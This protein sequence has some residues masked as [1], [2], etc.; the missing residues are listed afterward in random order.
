MLIAEIL[1]WFLLSMGRKAETV[2]GGVIPGFFMER[3]T[4]ETSFAQA[5][6]ASRKE[7]LMSGLTSTAAS[8]HNVDLTPL[9]T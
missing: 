7:I 1:G 9:Q 8:L 4:A 2:R 5:M 3:S 6:E